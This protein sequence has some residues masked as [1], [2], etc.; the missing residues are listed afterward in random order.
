MNFPLCCFLKYWCDF[1]RQV[2]VSHFGGHLFKKVFHVSHARRFLASTAETG[3]CQKWKAQEDENLGKL[4]TFQKNKRHHIAAHTFIF[5]GGHVSGF[6]LGGT[7]MLAA[8]V[9]PCERGAGARAPLVGNSKGKPLLSFSCLSSVV[10][11]Q[12]KQCY[13]RQRQGDDRQIL[14]PS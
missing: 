6:V 7:R 11:E 12:S 1:I 10:A 9:V 8:C 4:L 2:K 5:F 14:N 3:F 13:W